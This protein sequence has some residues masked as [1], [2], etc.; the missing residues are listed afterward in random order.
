MA[1]DDII[2]L[3]IKNSKDYKLN[4]CSCDIDI[5]NYFKNNNFDLKDLN[6]CDF[7]VLIY[8]IECHASPEL[9]EYLLNN[10]D[11]SSLNYTF[12]AGEN[13][14]DYFPDELDLYINDCPERVPLFSAICEQEFYIANK[15]IEKG[16]SLIYRNS[17]E[18][19]ILEYLEENNYISK[20]TLRY[21]FQK[22]FPFSLITSSFVVKLI[23]NELDPYLF[24]S[25]LECCIFDQQCI[26]FFI[27]LYKSKTPLSNRQL[28]EILSKEK[29]KIPIYNKLYEAV[30]T[31]SMEWNLPILTLLLKYD[32]RSLNEQLQTIKKFSLIE[33]VKKKEEELKE[34]EEEI[35]E[36]LETILTIEIL[37]NY[38]FDI[39]NILDLL[40]Y[41]SF[42]ILFRKALKHSLIKLL[43]VYT[44]YGIRGRNFEMVLSVVSHITSKEL[45]NF[46]LEKLLQCFNERNNDAKWKEKDEEE[47]QDENNTTIDLSISEKWELRHIAQMIN[48]GLAL[49]DF[50]LVDHLLSKYPVLQSNFTIDIRPKNTKNI[51]IQWLGEKIN[52]DSYYDIFSYVLMPTTDVKIKK[53]LGPTLFV[54][55]LL[56]KE[57]RFLKF[58]INQRSFY[59][60]MDNKKHYSPWIEAIYK[61]DFEKIKTMIQESNQENIIMN[62]LRSQKIEINSGYDRYDFTPLIIA[63]LLNRENMVDF[64]ID[65]FDIDELDVYGYGL[66]HYVILKEDVKMVTYLINDYKAKVNYR[67]NSEGRG[68]LPLEIAI[69]L[70]NMEICSL[71][72]SAST[73]VIDDLNGEGATALITLLRIP[74]NSFKKPSFK[75]K[76]LKRLVKEGANVNA[77]DR[78]AISAVNYASKESNKTISS[79]LIQLLIKNGATTSLSA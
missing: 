77:T 13:F 36:L 64:L 56:N 51:N 37:S 23:K 57:Y 49:E 55:S 73:A 15:L 69:Q 79:S 26:L 42:Y 74:V 9:I 47:L 41:C 45:L 46:I 7:D 71:L 72:L 58:L 1:R 50:N 35:L 25:F 31:S 20:K 38:S 32:G 12:I 19:N 59:F 40:D 11:D 78:F 43:N 76:C 17:E 10:R 70:E 75:L 61:N 16:A 22:G 53:K 60:T 62:G 65:Y 63:Y 34:K 5:K 67:E 48:L 24:Q 14:E 27:S 29:R 52:F 30:I 54:L 6:S 8:A 3:I 33:V 66:L 68:H 44:N 28:N 39:A 2:Q 21:I 4:G 18:R